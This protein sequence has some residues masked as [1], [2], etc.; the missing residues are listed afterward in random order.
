MYPMTNKPVTNNPLYT[1]PALYMATILMLAG[2]GLFTTYLGLRLT[3]DGVN[4]MIIGSLTTAYYAGLVVGAKIAHRLIANFGHIRS[5]VACAGLATIATL[6]YVM[7]E[8]LTV[9]IALRFLLGIVMMNQYTVL[10]SWLN[11]QAENN[12]RG[13]AFAGYMIATDLGLM[14]GQGYLHQ[15]PLLDYKPLIIISML[16]A[17]CLIPIAMTRRVHPAK[18]V[19]APLEIGF[20]WKKVPQ[21]L[22]MIFL[23]GIMVGSFYGLAAVYASKMG[24]NTSN[25][26]L[27]VMVCIA[28][29]FVSQW[30]MGWLS[31]HFNRAKL[32][33]INAVLFAIS[34]IPLW[35]FIELPTWL[36]MCFGF[37]GGIFLFTFY[38][39]AI[40]FAN[41]NVEQSKRVALSALLLATYGIGASIGPMILGSLMEY[42]KPGAYYIA[43]SVV[44]FLI[45][46]W[47]RPLK[48]KY[49][50]G[51]PVQHVVITRTI[52]A[53]GATLDPRIDEVPKDLIVEAPASIGR[54]DGIEDAPNPDS[55]NQSSQDDDTSKEQEK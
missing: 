46:I 47:V 42:F 2:S 34:V 3:A 38:P 20:F 40:A 17:A 33:R 41:D 32:I 44:A 49:A 4:E 37:L 14:L 22:V 52:S 36:I 24:L 1:F 6:A 55:E 54:S 21:A 23:V 11:E 8:N 51:E 30:P 16:F 13:L 31:D 50:E 26:S 53:M 25:A 19:A 29:G 15:F 12:Q 10:E 39:L 18:I 43:S 27:F 35:G 5:Y 28:A 9:W 45:A 48:V 7:I